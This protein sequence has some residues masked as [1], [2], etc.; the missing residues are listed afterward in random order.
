VYLRKTTTAPMRGTDILGP[1]FQ[2][3]SITHS[4]QQRIDVLQIGA[5]VGV[6]FLNGYANASKSVRRLDSLLRSLPLPKQFFA[7]YEPNELYQL[8]SS[9]GLQTRLRV[10]DINPNVLSIVRSQREGKQMAYELID[11]SDIAQQ[12]V[13]ESYDVCVILNVFPHIKLHKERVQAVVNLIELTKIGGY[14]A[15]A[16]L[17]EIS[18]LPLDPDYCLE[19]TGKLLYRKVPVCGR[20]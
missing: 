3:L 7:S 6:R 4:S 8:I 19:Q 15:G 9:L 5:G 2:E 1:L 13:T 16:P 10:A 18:V 20:R 12:F 17:D 14:I 11:I